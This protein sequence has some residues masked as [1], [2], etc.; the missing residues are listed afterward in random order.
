MRRERGLKKRK[1]ELERGREELQRK[2]HGLG[3]EEEELEIA[4][5][6]SSWMWEGTTTRWFRL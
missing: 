2:R 5:L 6:G 4:E 1:L 3:F